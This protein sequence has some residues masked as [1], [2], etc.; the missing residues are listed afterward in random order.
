MIDR[1]WFEERDRLD[2]LSA[3][4]EEFSLGKEL[5]YLD[6]NS[7]GALP[8]RVL[9]R[10]SRVIQTEWG[11]DLIGSWTDNRWMELPSIIGDKIAKLI[12][13]NA[14]EVI[15]CDST[16]VNLF[17]VLSAALTR[18]PS[19]HVILSDR[20]NFPTDLYI[21]RGVISTVGRNVEMRLVDPDELEE[22]IDSDV[23]VLFLTHVNFRNGARYDM[24]HIT[25]LAHDV[26][27][28]VIWD[29]AHSAGA[30]P[31]DLNACNVDFAVGCGYK[32]LNGGPGAP[33]YVYVAE[34]LQSTIQNPLT[35]WM[36]HE[37]PFDFS[38]HYSR[39]TGIRQMLCGTPPILSMA[40][41]EVGVD[42][43]LTVDLSVVRDK[44]VHLTEMFIDGVDERGKLK[45][46]SVLTPRAPDRRGSQVS[47][48]HPRGFG[49]IKAMHDQ[50]IV[51]DFRMPDVLRFGFA[52]LYT[53]YTDVWDALEALQGIMEGNR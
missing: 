36:G 22:Q 26:G 19:R 34:A 6:G 28:L 31:L 45:E 1:R 10:V 17:K 25:K 53:R 7:L 9:N 23:A 2:P 43:L 21:A 52:P 44:S 5:V 47:L 16:S 46:F 15:V 13:A 12:G 49:I 8:K 27:A 18:S 41:L 4:R 35:G 33:A 3:F 24:K 37:S 39:A 30:M 14:G 38:N 32:Y 48:S 20:T 42:L 29:L 50:G 11:C 51:A 40:A